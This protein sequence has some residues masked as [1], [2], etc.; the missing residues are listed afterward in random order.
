[1]KR[2][3]SLGF[4]SNFTPKF[5]AASIDPEILITLNGLALVLLLVLFLY[6]KKFPKQ[7]LIATV[8]SNVIY[9][10]YVFSC[11]LMY[12]YMMPEN[13]AIVLGGY[14][15]YIAT[16][17]IYFAGIMM[18]SIV[19]EW[20]KLQNFKKSRVIQIVGFIIIAIMFIYPFK[21]YFYTLY[22]KPDV[23]TSVRQHELNETTKVFG[24]AYRSGIAKP[25]VIYYSKQSLNDYGYLGYLLSYEYLSLDEA[26]VLNQSS[27][28][29]DQEKILSS[30]KE[31][32]YIV[33]LDSDKDFNHLLSA[34]FGVKKPLGTFKIN[35]KENGMELIPLQ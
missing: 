5:I 12:V 26:V 18:L 23:A 1:M 19:N 3:L 4:L 33:V 14:Y 16:I 10:I 17:W 28:K 35:H 15:R 31:M 7:L 2:L 25:K 22:T 29:E 24:S 30:M 11:Y 9:A 34:K 32:D 13:E 8:F 27:T 20:D 21:E 6:T